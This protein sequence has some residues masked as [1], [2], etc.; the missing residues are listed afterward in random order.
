VKQKKPTKK[1][2]DEKK[3]KKREK[4]KLVDDELPSLSHL[5]L[6]DALKKAMDV[7]WN[8]NS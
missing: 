2:V 5:D 4:E 6:E 1:T 7:P 8:G 3:R